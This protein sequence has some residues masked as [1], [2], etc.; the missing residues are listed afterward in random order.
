MQDVKNSLAKQMGGIDPNRLGLFDSKNKLL[1][2][3]LGLI[4]QNK[5]VVDGR[6][7]LVKDLGEWLVRALS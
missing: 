7:I 1:K 2:D 3:R 5:E 6:E 4:K